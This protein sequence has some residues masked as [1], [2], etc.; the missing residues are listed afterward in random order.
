MSYVI[1][2]GIKNEFTKQCR[3]QYNKDKNF[4]DLYNDVLIFCSEKNIG[5]LYF[6]ILNCWNNE[7]H[8]MTD[9]EF[10]TKGDITQRIIN[11]IDNPII[12]LYEIFVKFIE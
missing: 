7:F 4:R 8:K 12:I 11:I 6:W 2:N 10:T 1:F 9:E 3:I 5:I